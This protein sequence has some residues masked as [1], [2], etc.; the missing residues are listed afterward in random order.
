MQLTLGFTLFMAF[1]LLIKYVPV[2][3]RVKQPNRDVTSAGT[4]GY[5]NTLRSKFVHMHY[6]LALQ[7]SQPLLEKMQCQNSIF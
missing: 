6:A 7:I 3:S 4:L 1:V 2:L 5:P